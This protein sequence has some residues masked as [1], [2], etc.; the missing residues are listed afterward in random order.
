MHFIA[1]RARSTSSC[2][3]CFS[4]SVMSLA[5]LLDLPWR[6]SV[7]G[8]RNANPHRF[9][10]RVFLCHLGCETG[11]SSDDEDQFA[12]RRR[13]SHIEKDRRERTID[14]DRQRTNL[15]TYCAFKRRDEF[16]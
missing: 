2:A 10:S 9:L 4:S 12:E 11:D 15:L 1:A 6:R 13:K 16:D 7:V 8:H 14:I 5:M 3:T